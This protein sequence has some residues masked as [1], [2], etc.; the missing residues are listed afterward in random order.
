MDP[1]RNS[2]SVAGRQPTSS[3][4][5]FAMC[6]ALLVAQEDASELT[7]RIRFTSWTSP[8]H[9]CRLCSSK[10]ACKTSFRFVCISLLKEGDLKRIVPSGSGMISSVRAEAGLYEHKC[11]GCH[12]RL[13][14][15]LPNPADRTALCQLLSDQSS[16]N[17]ACE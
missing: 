13:T 10:T 4:S 3:A 11:Q 1:I 16:Q 7:K 9:F 8:R 14:D 6:K 17:E 5:S 15:T 2:R 12:V